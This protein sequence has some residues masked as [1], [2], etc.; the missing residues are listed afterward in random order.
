MPFMKSYE[1]SV[2]TATNF[3]HGKGLVRHFHYSTLV[4][5][6]TKFNKSIVDRA[7]GSV[8]E[9]IHGVLLAAI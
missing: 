7:L 6:P 3:S 8:S 1:W 4:P 5:V 9:I 2:Q